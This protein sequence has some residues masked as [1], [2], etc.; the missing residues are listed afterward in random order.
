MP[1][2]D[3]TRVDAGLFH[4]FHHSWI[5]DTARALNQGVL[6]GEYSP[7]RSRGPEASDRTC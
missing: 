3:W 4:H 1:V 7:S 2:H 5:E 6:P